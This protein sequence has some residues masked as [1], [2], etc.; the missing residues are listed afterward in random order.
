MKTLQEISIQC[1]FLTL[2]I[3]YPT[4]KSQYSDKEKST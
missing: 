4:I 3:V 2:N 1:N